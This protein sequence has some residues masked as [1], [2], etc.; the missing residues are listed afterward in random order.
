MSKTR[1]EMIIDTLRDNPDKKFTA[2]EL[3]HEFVKRYPQEIAEKQTNPRYATIED[4][5]FQLTAE[6][7]GERTAAAK[8]RCPNIMTQD[9]PRPR[10]YYWGDYHRITFYY[11]SLP[12]FSC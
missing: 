7:G 10:L 9:Q 8:Q 2:R 3:A 6:I 12:I 4:L 5:I 1:V 11:E